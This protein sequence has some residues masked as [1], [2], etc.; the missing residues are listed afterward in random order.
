MELTRQVKPATTSRARPPEG[1]P[2][3]LSRFNANGSQFYPADRAF[4]R[5][6]GDG[7]TYDLTIPSGLL[8]PFV[9]LPVSDISPIWNPETFFNAVVVSG[10][11]WPVSEVAPEAT[12]AGWKDTVIAY[13]G[14]VTRV[15]AL[16][17]IPGLYVGQC[18]ILSREDNEMMLP[19]CVGTPGIDCPLEPL[20]P[21]CSG[22]D[23]PQRA[24]AAFARPLFGV[25]VRVC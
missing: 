16:F 1:R 15:N 20:Q 23:G 24:Q 11:T 7:Q 10:D 2:T 22:R 17:D 8:I 5:G 13:P 12:E 9:P 14:E 25:P 6:P 21:R 4:Y 3:A 19:Y 18:H